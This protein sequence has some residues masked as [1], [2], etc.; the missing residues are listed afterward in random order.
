M[1]A[2]LEGFP[3][4]KLQWRGFFGAGNGMKWSMAYRA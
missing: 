2:K 1:G 4:E 3:A